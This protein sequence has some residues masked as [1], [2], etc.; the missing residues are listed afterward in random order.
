M[1]IAGHIDVASSALLQEALG[2][3][4]MYYKIAASMP[5]LSCEAYFRVSSLAALEL[6]G[7]PLP[8]YL[9]RS[10]LTTDACSPTLLFQYSS[11]SLRAWAFPPTARG[12]CLHPLDV[13][14]S[15]PLDD[16]LECLCVNL[17]Q[18]NPAANAL[19]TGCG[20]ELVCA[21]FFI[22]HLGW[23]RGAALTVAVNKSVRV[24]M[25]LALLC[26]RGLWRSL[27]LGPKRAAIACGSRGRLSSA[28]GAIE[29]AE[30][31]VSWR[32]L[33]VFWLAAPQFTAPVRL[34]LP[35]AAA[36]RAE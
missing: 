27:L 10:L 18:V 20:V 1:A 19:L 23:E 25:W 5:L 26:C 11:R 31:L 15:S 30:A 36:R 6:V 9:H 22:Y 12:R 14:C 8:R 35:R 24:G 16:H 28:N 21:W 4:I 33:R 17:G 3:A 29:P 32:E 34:G 2:Y 13:A 7:G